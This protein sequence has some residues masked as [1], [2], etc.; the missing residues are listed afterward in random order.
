MLI[1][2]HLSLRKGIPVLLLSI[3]LVTVHSCKTNGSDNPVSLQ[4]DTTFLQIPGVGWQTFN[5]VADEDK[6]MDG[7]RFKSGTAYYR[8]YWVTLEP[9]EGQYAFGMIDTLLA[10]CRENGQALAFRIMCEDPWGEGLPGW[11]IKKGIKR[12]FSPCP[13]EGAHYSPDMSDTVFMNSHK[14]L[15]R[16]FGKRYDGHPDIA[17]LDIGSVGLWGEW[18]IYCDP[19]LMPSRKI[20]QEITDLYYESFPNTPLT[21]LM[22]DDINTDYAVS[23]GN[24]GWRGDS[25]GDADSAGGGWNHHQFYY[26][27]THNRLPEAWKTGTVA[28]EPG[29]PEGTLSGITVPVK[30]IVDDAI[31]WHATFAHNKSKAIP[32][33]QI[34]EIERLVKKMGFRLVLRN[35]K[36]ED[37]VYAGSEMPVEMKFEN[38]GIAPPYR[39]YRIAFRLKDKNNEYFG[40]SL[41]DL[42]IRGW[43]PGEKIAS[44]VFKIP[45]DV[46]PGKYEVEIA[47]VLYN[48]IV[49][50][51]PLANHGRTADGWYSTGTLRIRQ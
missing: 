8:W 2:S 35:M 29:E 5:R 32:T 44:S 25:W 23:K 17:L 22:G 24:C 27:P 16:A 37:V 20:R 34:S 18:H 26:W 28:M 45:S 14:K 41:T 40:T 12:T 36:F 4:E 30:R 21:A 38:T 48:S 50:N 15:V 46:K 42:S 7:L 49:H 6:S 3:I 33:E 13:E 19:R 47:L 43:L 11:L 51:I 1:M 39:D 10:R 31:A 9:R